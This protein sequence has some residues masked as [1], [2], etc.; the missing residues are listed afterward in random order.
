[1][2]HYGKRWNRVSAKALPDEASKNLI[3]RVMEGFSDDSS[4]AEE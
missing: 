4:V 2:S 1:V 3:R